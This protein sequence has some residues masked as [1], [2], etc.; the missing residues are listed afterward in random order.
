MAIEEVYNIIN[1]LEKGE[2]G[3]I[4]SWKQVSYVFNDDIGEKGVAGKLVDGQWII[5]DKFSPSGDGL[6]AYV[7]E[8]SD[9][10]TALCYY[11]LAFA[12]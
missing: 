6:C 3:G 8:T 9:D 5:D 11:N 1:E 2:A 4:G 7:F 10:I 12:S